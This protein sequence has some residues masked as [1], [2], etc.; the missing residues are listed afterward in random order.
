MIEYVK[1]AALSMQEATLMR[2]PLRVSALNPAHACV[3]RYARNASI[4]K[5]YLFEQIVDVIERISIS[6]VKKTYS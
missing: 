2:K 6:P 3:V 4:K 1:N 5:K